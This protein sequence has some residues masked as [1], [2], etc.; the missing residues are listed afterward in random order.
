MADYT[1]AAVTLPSEP[2]PKMIRDNMGMYIG[3]NLEFALYYLLKSLI[4]EAMQDAA[5]P[6]TRF[7]ITLHDDD[8]YS[9]SNNADLSQLDID[10]TPTVSQLGQAIVGKSWSYLPLAGALSSRFQRTLA[11]GRAVYREDLVAGASGRW[12]TMIGPPARLSAFCPIQP[13]GFAAMCHGI[14]SGR[15]CA[16]LPPSR[17][18]THFGS[19]TNKSAW[20]PHSA[21]ATDSK[22]ILLSSSRIMATNRCTF[23]PLL[24]STR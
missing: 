11:T 16:S 20:R 3:G 17:R 13:C 19:S 24:A 1:Q 18:N 8:S 15:I 2:W 6:A 22:A 4:K 5:Y 23:G 14:H 12:R 9:L 10:D 7:E 21:T